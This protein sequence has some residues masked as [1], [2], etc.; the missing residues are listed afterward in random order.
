VAYLLLLLL[1]GFGVHRFYLRSTGVGTLMLVSTL[2]GF[3]LR[4]PLVVTATIFVYDLFTIPSQVRRHN[5]G[6][7]AET[8]VRE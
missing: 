1:G 3:L 4:L 5:D 7:M 8:G 6:L 2:L